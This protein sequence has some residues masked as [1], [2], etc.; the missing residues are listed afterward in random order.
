M[1]RINFIF[2]YL[3][4]KSKLGTAMSPRHP[5]NVTFSF[6]LVPPGFVSRISS[7]ILTL[8]RIRFSLI[9]INVGKALAWKGYICSGAFSVIYD[10]SHFKNIPFRKKTILVN[11]EYLSIQQIFSD[12]NHFLF[13]FADLKKHFQ[14]F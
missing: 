4:I 3:C 2:S 6:C 5:S 8:C 13:G 14:D 7:M 10:W 1:N 11:F 9:L 12:K